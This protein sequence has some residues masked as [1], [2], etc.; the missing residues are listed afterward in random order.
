MVVEAARLLGERV[1]GVVGADTFNDLGVRYS[2]EEIEAFLQPLQADFSGAMGEVV[3]SMFVSTSD[4][5]L[6]NWIVEDMSSARPEVGIGAL[7]G[8]VAWFNNESADAFRDLAVPVRLINSDY[9]P[10]NVDAGKEY[11]SSFDAVFMSGVGHFVM[12]E[13]PETFNRLLV[14]IVEEF[15]SVSPSVGR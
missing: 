8:M 3:R 14:D 2:E 6:M 13:D 12:M 15:S 4:S 9:N 1:E 7:E 11:T 5:T 10:T